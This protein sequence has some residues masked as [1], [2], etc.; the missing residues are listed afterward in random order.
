MKLYH[1]QSLWQSLIQ[2]YDILPEYR[3]LAIKANQTIEED[4]ELK[5][6][7]RI[8]ALKRIL[9][10]AEKREFF[11]MQEVCCE[12]LTEYCKEGV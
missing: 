4:S 5:R 2:S 11:D 8:V 9:K 12:L 1:E 7:M 3:S 6:N 10:H